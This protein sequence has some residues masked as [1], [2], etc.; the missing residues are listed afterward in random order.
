MLIKSKTTH[1]WPVASTADSIRMLFICETTRQLPFLLVV[2]F[3]IHVHAY[4]HLYITVR[5][6]HVTICTQFALHAQTADVK[7]TTSGVSMKPD[8]MTLPTHWWGHIF[9]HS[10][11]NFWVYSL[12]PLVMPYSASFSCCDKRNSKLKLFYLRKKETSLGNVVFNNF[13]YM[14]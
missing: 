10:H 14:Q 2:L 8:N 1:C 4:C 3:L 7:K 5:H 6:K 9:R 13:S 11:P 12:H